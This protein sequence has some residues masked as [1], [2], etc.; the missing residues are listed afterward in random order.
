[1]PSQSTS[2]AAP[3]P[4]RP[5]PFVPS[6]LTY[7]LRR[8]NAYYAHLAAIMRASRR[9]TG[10]ARKRAAALGLTID[11]EN[12][13]NLDHKQVSDIP[14]P[15]LDIVSSSISPQQ[16]SHALANEVKKLKCNTARPVPHCSIP[17][18]VVNKEESSALSSVSVYSTVSLSEPEV[19]VRSRWSMS[20]ADEEEVDIELEENIIYSSDY[21]EGM[22]LSNSAAEEEEDDL[23]EE[24][25]VVGAR[26]DT[27]LAPRLDLPVDVTRFSWG[28]ALTS[29]YAS[30]SSA[31]SSSGP[32]TP[33]SYPPLFLLFFRLF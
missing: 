16:R 26:A 5:F 14:L 29:D 28:S 31:S 10:H 15:I 1:M 27:R 20:T 25:P 24:K 32:A 12:A 19:I 9:P 6:S 7:T 2:I 3:T 4:V 17:Q 8:A 11:I 18:D 33:V 21:E 13:R 30:S 22:D 23:F